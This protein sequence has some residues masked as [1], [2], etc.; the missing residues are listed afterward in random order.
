MKLSCH[1]QEWYSPIYLMVFFYF[2]YAGTSTRPALCLTCCASWR[3]DTFSAALLRSSWVRRS[4][5]FIFQMNNNK[6]RRRSCCLIILLINWWHAHI[7]LQC[8]RSSRT[9]P[10]Q[11]SRCLW[12]TWLRTTTCSSSRAMRWAF[13]QR[14]SPRTWVGK[15]NLFRVWL[16]VVCLF[17]FL[18]SFFFSFS[19]FFLV[20][21]HVLISSS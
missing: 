18:F 16:F 11:A 20:F 8:Q 3:T 19:F 14:P 21:P 6:R 7:Y 15:K 2:W 13:Q 1:L 4:V 12:C 9:S 5:S 17:L 10:R